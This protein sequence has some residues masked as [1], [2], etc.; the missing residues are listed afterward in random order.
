MKKSLL[1]FVFFSIAIFS[2]RLL[3]QADSSVINANMGNAVAENKGLVNDETAISTGIRIFSSPVKDMLQIDGLDASAKT[4]ITVSSS[5]GKIIYQSRSSGSAT[6]SANVSKLKPG[7][8][9]IT[10]KEKDNST[11]LRFIKV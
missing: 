6:Y 3:A 7:I 2:N 1:L 5:Y 4:I 8:Y 10:I 9:Y 11:L